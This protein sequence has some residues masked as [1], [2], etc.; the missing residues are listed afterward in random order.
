[1]SSSDARVPEVARRAEKTV[2]FNGEQGPSTA[3][4]LTT[5]LAGNN[6]DLTYTA[7]AA[8]ADG[9]DITIAY[10]DPGANDAEL[11]V[12]VTGTAIVVN[13]ATD[14][15]GAITS[16]AA[17]V[18]AA[19]DGEVAAAALVTP[20]NAG[21]N[22][23]SGVV[24]ALAA[25]PLTGGMTPTT[26][27]FEVSGVVAVKLFARCT[28]SLA[29]ATATVAAGTA[30]S[31]TGLI[32]QTTATDIDANELWHDASPD[33]SV[34]AITVL[35]ERIVAQDIIQTVGTAG[36]TDGTLA[37]YCLWRPIS[38]DGAVAAA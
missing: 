27:L 29:G 33:A 10:V 26:T 19:N 37:Y 28:E 8:G 1:M 21:G 3:A 38:S 36:V 25:T 15:N 14:E 23:G 35:T 24:T 18:D 22:D 20:A 11:G 16:T 9:N 4:A 34:E 13:L 31:A 17:E 30:L 32:A 7:V 12:V 6:N 5:A 2:A